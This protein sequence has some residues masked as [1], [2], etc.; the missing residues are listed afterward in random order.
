MFTI[1]TYN[2][3]AFLPLS[4]PSPIARYAFQIAQFKHFLI[5]AANF[6]TSKPLFAFKG[7][8]G[9][10]FV[11]ALCSYTTLTIPTQA[12]VTPQVMLPYW[13]SIK[14]P[15]TTPL[16]ALQAIKRIMRS[17]ALTNAM[18]LPD[19]KRGSNQAYR[20]NL[21]RSSMLGG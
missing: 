20:Y 12:K 14:L 3:F 11:I 18:A 13:K 7:Y 10:F 2:H 21:L 15:I 1:D 9:S 16:N 17:F 8:S 4:C 19:T 6:S 5:L